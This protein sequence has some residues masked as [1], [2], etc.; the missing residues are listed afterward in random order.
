MGREVQGWGGKNLP[1]EWE[2][3]SG[4]GGLDSVYGGNLCCWQQ[5]NTFCSGQE[6]QVYLSQEA[7]AANVAIVSEMPG[8]NYCLQIKANPGALISLQ[9][10]ES[11]VIVSSLCQGQRLMFPLQRQENEKENPKSAPNPEQEF[12]EMLL[13][14]SFDAFANVFKLC[15]G[16]W[17]II[18]KEEFV[19]MKS[20]W[21]SGDLR[22]EQTKQK[23]TFKRCLSICMWCLSICLSCFSVCMWCLS[24]C[25]R[26]LQN[27]AQMEPLKPRFWEFGHLEIPGKG[28][29]SEL[30]LSCV[31][32]DQQVPKGRLWQRG[33]PSR[34]R[35]GAAGLA[36]G[37]L[38]DSHQ[39][40]E[41]QERWGKLPQAFGSG[42]CNLLHCLTN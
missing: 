34:S 14:F 27:A 29:V 2:V 42:R 24:I 18:E 15:S 9:F 32:V 8:R 21:Y 33:V 6:T 19:S 16:S 5:M 35:V 41:G 36:G 40:R 26:F 20:L 28:T 31:G 22:G 13:W 30:G 10:R 11:P 37:K 25:M 12:R 23:N 7:F 39:P 1:W 4:K 17:L 38:G 3:K